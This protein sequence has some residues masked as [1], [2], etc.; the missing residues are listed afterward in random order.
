MNH[1]IQPTLT[2]STVNAPTIIL[3]A[4]PC[5]ATTAIYNYLSQYYPISTVILEQPLSRW[6]LLRGRAK[7]LSWLQAIGQAAFMLLATPFLSFESR[8][9]RRHIAQRLNTTSPIPLQKIINVPSVNAPQTQ[10]IIRQLNPQLILVNGTRIIHKNTLNATSALFINLH[11]GI[12]PLYRGVHGGYWALVQ[13]QPQYCG[14][15]IHKI[16]IGIDTG[17]ILAQTI[18]QPTS[19]DN[20]NTYPL[21]QLAEGLPLFRQTIAYLLDP[22]LPAPSTIPSLP[23]QSRLWY[24]PTLFQ[25]IVNRLRL[26]VK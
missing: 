24:H 3:L 10:E 7:R 25:Y 15:T 26:K 13:Q 6:Q 21:L 19:E 20:F 16:D 4:I 8:R 23:A 12:T 18:I 1:S 2:P 11:V 17:N 22:S 9:R 14:V 5:P